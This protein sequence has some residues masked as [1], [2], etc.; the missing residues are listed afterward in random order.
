MSSPKDFSNLLWEF[1]AI[2]VITNFLHYSKTFSNS[3]ISAAAAFCFTFAVGKIGSDSMTL[4][5]ELLTGAFVS[6]VLGRA[7]VVRTS[8][9]NVALM[10]L[11]HDCGEDFKEFQIMGR[12]IVNIFKNWKAMVRMKPLIQE[13]SYDLPH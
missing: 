3:E 11:L 4:P 7:D 13:C 1:S 10:P 5:T 9:T 2:A 6:C 8:T 12:E